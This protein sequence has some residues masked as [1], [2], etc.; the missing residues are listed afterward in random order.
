M[1]IQFNTWSLMA[2][3]LCAG[4]QGQA[5]GSPLGSADNFA[6]LGG[7]T[8]TNAGLSVI[9]GDLGVWPGTTAPGFPPG[10]LVGQFHLGDPVAQQ[11]Q[12]DVTTA[13]D[14]FAAMLVDQ[15]LTG[16]DLGGMTLAPGVY[17]FASS[18][19]LTGTLTLDAQGDPLAVWVFQIGST[20][21]TSAGSA[22]VM[23]MPATYHA[24][25][26]THLIAL[27]SVRSAAPPS[28]ASR[29]TV[30]P[31]GRMATS[32]WR[33]TAVRRFMID[34]RALRAPQL[35]TLPRMAQRLS[36][37]EVRHIAKL[38]RLKLSDAELDQ[39]TTPS[40]RNRGRRL[41]YELV[42]D[43][44][45]LPR[46]PAILAVWAALAGPAGGAPFVTVPAARP[47]PVL[48]D[49][50]GPGSARQRV[51]FRKESCDDAGTE[52]SWVYLA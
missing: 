46:W 47:T 2:V 13:Y 10:V 20:L 24:S 31:S 30:T 6:V 16:V 21:T 12:S 36:L 7:S 17:F 14:T 41:P 27:P 35:A 33:K 28:Q 18:A 22:V 34:G 37:D 39:F 25:G 15:A 42:P 9:T 23:T 29:R 43:G 51:L 48:R 1:Q 50:R 32:P 44:A 11:A 8:V 19:G 52:Q 26:R 45:R 5:F 40:R 3:A 38:A 49:F 4:V